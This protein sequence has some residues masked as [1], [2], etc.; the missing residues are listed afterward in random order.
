[1]GGG[2]PGEPALAR[3]MAVAAFVVLPVEVAVGGLGRLDPSVRLGALAVA[4]LST[5]L[6]LSLEF[7]AL[8]RLTARTY[9]ILVTMEPAV[10][11]LVGA[12]LLGQA[13]GLQGLLA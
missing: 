13:M 12:V 1:L 2:V 9:G 8:K 7:E 3:G 11:A 4:I 5:A 10:A 6:P